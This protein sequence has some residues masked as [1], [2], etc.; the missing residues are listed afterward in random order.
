MST[1]KLDEEDRVLFANR[2]VDDATLE[3]KHGM[4]YLYAARGVLDTDKLVEQHNITVTTNEGVSKVLDFLKSLGYES[5][6]VDGMT[7]LDKE[8]DD[9]DD[10]YAVSKK[11]RD[12]Y[13]FYKQPNSYCFVG[14][15]RRPKKD[16]QEES[17]VHVSLGFAG[18]N[19]DIKEDISK[20]HAFCKS[21]KKDPLK[22][23]EIY[24]IATS[25]E[26]YYF[27]KMGEE[28]EEYIK[29][30]YTEEH[31]EVRSYILE[32]L[33]TKKPNGR[34]N[35]FFGP[36]GTGK[37]HFIKSLLGHVESSIFVYIPPHLVPQIS[38]P[39]FITAVIEYRNNYPNKKIIFVLEDA[40]QVLATRMSDN[41]CDI[42]GLLNLTDGFLASSFDIRIIATTNSKAEDIDS[43]IIRPGR[44]CTKLNF[45]PLNKEQS[46][47]CFANLTEG[48]SLQEVSNKNQHTLAEI[49][50]LVAESKVPAVSIVSDRNKKSFGF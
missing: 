21:I 3:R 14:F 24:T 44:L 9:D 23:G 30:N 36:P 25:G 32:Q 17:S 28:G 8:E 29:T 47:V 6:H 50:A 27:S 49:Y 13:K 43:A 46:E 48:K 11:G 12:Y 26:G 45:G 35:I 2:L 42:N 10:I 39:A 4:V 31:N 16:G 34:L 15:Y 18:S 41:I 5:F 40:D 38:N 20:A 22:T 33:R 7:A 19:E 1:K 37:T